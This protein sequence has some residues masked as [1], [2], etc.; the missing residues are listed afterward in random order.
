MIQNV[1]TGDGTERTGQRVATPNYHGQD[2]K[3][4]NET[5]L[6]PVIVSDRVDFVRRGWLWIMGWWGR[7]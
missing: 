5:P 7:G 2:S 1:V 4:R 6:S 3:W